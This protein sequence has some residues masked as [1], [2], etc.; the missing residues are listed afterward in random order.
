VL[1]S[2]GPVKEFFYGYLSNT[3][4]FLV[5][6]IDQWFSDQD[7]ARPTKCPQPLKGPKTKPKEDKTSKM[8]GPNG[9]RDQEDPI[10]LRKPS[11]PKPRAIL[12]PS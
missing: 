6:H 2:I 7:N 3:N 11:I 4:P 12:S 5:S 10:V 8:K 9:Q 1:P